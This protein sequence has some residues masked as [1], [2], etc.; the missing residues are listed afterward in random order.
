MKLISLE[1]A[2]FNIEADVH[3][4][5]IASGHAYG[6]VDEM[7]RA[8]SEKGLK[9]YGITEHTPSI[10]GS[11]DLIYFKNI[12]VIPRCMYDMD[13]WLG[14]EINIMGYNGEIDLP[15]NYFKYLDIRIAG[16]HEAIYKKGNREQNTAAYINVIKNPNI[17]IISHPDSCRIDYD[18]EAVCD[19]AKEYHTLLEVNNN[20]LRTRSR[21]SKDNVIRMLQYCKKINQP[22]VANSDAHFMSDIKNLSD[23]I[24]AIDEADFP[25]ELVLNTDAAKLKEYISKNHGRGLTLDDY[26]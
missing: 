11:C 18:I 19:A 7:C 25:Y 10:K 24:K 3:T 1:E 9:L 22:V 6:T 12:H 26:Y 17:D 4:H 15:E 5:T 2:M 21:K 8:A 20:S 13:I 23:S 16:I 14:A